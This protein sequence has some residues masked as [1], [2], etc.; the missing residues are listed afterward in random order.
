MFKTGK[1][2]VRRLG[3]TTSKTLD[4]IDEGLD[5]T[6]SLLALA[7]KSFDKINDL[8]DEMLEES[9]VKAKRKAE[10]KEL[11]HKIKLKQLKAELAGDDK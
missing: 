5:A 6:K 7:T 10:K 2:S 9:A 4:V 3:Q 8:T 1:K 11:K